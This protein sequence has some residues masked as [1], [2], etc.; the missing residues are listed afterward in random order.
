MVIL[1]RFELSP[2]RM[3]IHMRVA[4]IVKL[5][6]VELGYHGWTIEPKEGELLSFM[7]NAGPWSLE[8]ALGCTPSIS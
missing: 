1:V 6:G 2:D 4:Q 8:L 7:R 5:V 3:R